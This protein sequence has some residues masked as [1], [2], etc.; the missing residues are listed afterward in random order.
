LSANTLYNW[1]L[2][3]ARESQTT[4]QAEFIPVQV[5]RSGEYLPGNR[6]PIQIT[7]PNG[8]QL[9]VPVNTAPEAVL[10]WIDQLAKVH[11]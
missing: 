7:L 8:L 4:A 3:L 6:E 10:P 11:A 1:Q 2:K 5:D 9:A